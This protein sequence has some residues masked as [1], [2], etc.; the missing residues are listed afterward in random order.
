MI[1]RKKVLLLLV[2][3]LLLFVYVH[4][5]CFFCFWKSFLSL[6]RVEHNPHFQKVAHIIQ[7]V[8]PQNSADRDSPLLNSPA[9]YNET[10]CFVSRIT[11]ACQRFTTTFRIDQWSPWNRKTLTF[12]TP[13]TIKFTSSL[14]IATKPWNQQQSVLWQQLLWLLVVVVG[15]LSV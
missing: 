4:V 6:N 7:L 2:L 13:V 5:F 12:W 11:T 8:F 3:L 10:N 15:Y 9:P 14:K 1:Q